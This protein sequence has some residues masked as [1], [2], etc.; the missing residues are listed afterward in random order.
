MA[1]EVLL[2]MLSFAPGENILSGRCVLLI[3]L[4]L[5]PQWA[6]LYAGLDR[7]EALPPKFWVKVILILRT[8]ALT[9][10]EDCIK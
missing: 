7:V 5:L 3:I 4:G 8:R 10:G 2:A 6:Q 1:G 9:S